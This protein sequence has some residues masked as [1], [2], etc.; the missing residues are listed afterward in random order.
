MAHSPPFNRS[1]TSEPQRR[2]IWF[3]LHFWIGWLAALPIA[4]ICVSGGVLAFERELFQWEHREFFELEATGPSLSLQQV[5]EGYRTAVPPMTVNHLSLP[6]QA[7]HSF[8]AFV[9]EHRPEGDRTARVFMNPYTGEL[10]PLTAGFSITELLIDVHRRLTGGRPGR[11]IVAASSLVLVLTC[12]LG[13]ILWWPLRGRTFVR[14]WRRGQALDWHNALGLVALIPLAIMAATGVTFT[15]GPGL[16]SLMERLGGSQAPPGVESATLPEAGVPM[17]MDLIVERIR[18]AVPQAQITGIQPSNESRRPT[19]VFLTEG[20]RKVQINMDPY[21]GEELSRLDGTTSS[22]T[23]KFRR[24]VG[25]IHTA[26]PFNVIVRT[27]WGLLSLSG[28][29][30]AA[31]GLW[32]SVKRWRRRS[33]RRADS[34]PVPPA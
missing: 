7:E 9:T 12:L 27:I 25:A 11:L 22:L 1:Q 31:T 2:P 29:V 28:G 13:L 21:T 16:W 33:L 32:M 23:E 10:T 19:K 3:H 5:L 26:G 17:S 20:G 24:N 6:A 34:L 8:S 30:I 15:F 4:L 14:A 18:A